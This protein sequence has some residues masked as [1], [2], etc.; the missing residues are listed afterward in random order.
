MAN[1][2]RRGNGSFGSLSLLLL[3]PSASSLPNNLIFGNDVRE[4]IQKRV[5]DWWSLAPSLPDGLS[6][7]TTFVIGNQADSAMLISDDEV[8]ALPSEEGF[9]VRS[10]SDGSV[11]AVRGGSERGNSYGSYCLLELVGVRFMHPLSPTVLEHSSFSIESGINVTET[12][13]WPLRGWHYHTQHP[14]ELT[15]V[16]NGFAA[17]DSPAVGQNETWDSMV[18][19][20]DLFFQWCIANRLNFVEWLLLY[21]ESWADF[22]ASELRKSRLRQL[23]DLSTAAAQLVHD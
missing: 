15:E 17:V 21:E 9:I 7:S 8:A 10:S 13:H 23:T 14:L 4:A 1:S 18:P 2:R 5:A 6:N 19:Q 22:A 12:P 16:F 20:V 11:V 3:L